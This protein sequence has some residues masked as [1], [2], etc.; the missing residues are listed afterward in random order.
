[1]CEKSYYRKY[2][3]YKHEAKRHM[4]T[5]KEAAIMDNEE[6]QSFIDDDEEFEL[7]PRESVTSPR[8]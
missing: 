1:M 8:D 4:K 6:S 7:T 3:L 5:V 2:Q